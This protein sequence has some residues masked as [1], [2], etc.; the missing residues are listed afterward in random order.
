MANPNSVLKL[1]VGGKEFMTT[2]STLLSDQNS[3][4]AKMFSP[5]SNGRIPATQD[6]RGAFFI[7]RCPIYFGVILNFLRS[8]QFEKRANID[9]KFLR[10]EAEY[11][12]I[13]GNTI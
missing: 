8:G 4:L 1:N 7:D 6:D 13:Q 12:G 9:M 10:S 2:Q 11:F 5:D 3:M